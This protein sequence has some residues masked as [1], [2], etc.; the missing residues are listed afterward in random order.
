MAK[1]FISYS[2]KDI[3][4]AKQL[5]GE[6]Q[7]SD[8]DYW[9]DWDGIPPTV[10]WW[11]EIEKGI[12][13]ADIFLF[14]ISPDSSKSEV[15]L[16]EIN[17]AVKNGKRLIPLVAREIS[18]DEAP[19]HLNH[20]NWIFFR[21]TDDFDAALEKLLT[22]I[23]TDYEWAAAHRRLQ[24]KALEWKRNNKEKSFLL[25]GKDL[26]DAELDLATNSSKDPHPT[27]LQREYIFTSRK[28]AD[29]QRR[30]TTGISSAGIIAL[31]ILAAFG[32][33][34]A[35]QA[36]N[37]A[38]TAQANLVIAQTA[39]VD[40]QNKQVL[41]DNNA[42]TAVANEQEA[43]RQ[44][45]I[46]RAG[47]LAAQSESLISKDFRS[48]LLLGIE[49]FQLLDNLQTRG[50]LLD[51]TNSNPA[52]LQYLA[53]HT[54]MVMSVA[55]SPDGKTLASSSNDNTIIL[56]DV[57]SRAPLGQPLTGHSQ[58]VSSVAFSPDGR[59]LASGSWD[60]TIIL[61]DIST[62]KPIGQPLTEHTDRVT[63]VA[64]SP[65][66]RT[67][68]SGSKDNTII[69]WDVAT[70]KPISRPLP[71]NVDNGDLTFSSDGRYFASA[72]GCGKSNST[73]QCIQGG[74][75]LWDVATRT[76]TGLPFTGH[77][78]R[79]ESVAFSPDSRILASGS[80]DNTIILWDVAT[81]K[82]I[83][84]PLIGHANWVRSVAFS[85]DSKILASGD[86]DATIFIWDVSTGRPISQPLIGHTS[87][88]SSLAFSPDG[89]TLASGSWDF[90]IS[91]WGVPTLLISSTAAP[92][93]PAGQPFARHTDRVN[94]VAF[95]P[96]GKI[97]ASGSNDTSV[98]LW[99][100]ATGNS[101]DQPLIGLTSPLDQPY[102]VRSV[103]FSPDGKILASGGYPD[104]I[105]WDI[106]THKL[107]GQLLTEHT[108]WVESVAFSPDGKILASGSD[109]GNIILTDVSTGE[110]V[111]QPLI[112]HTDWVMSVAFSP[113]GNTLASGS[114]DGSVILWEISS[115]KP[116]D[117]S[118]TW[119]P[120]KINSVAFSPDGKTLASAYNDNTIILW[121]V[122]SGDPI[123]QPLIGHTHEV[124]SIAFSPDGKNLISG[125]W[126]STVILWDLATH[127]P[128]GQPLVGHTN[129]VW[130]V[131]FSP[132]GKTIA[133]SS[134]DNTIILWDVDPA[135][136]I[137][138]SCQ[139]AG[140]NFTR[141]EWEKFGFTEPYRKTCEQWPLESET[142]TPSASSAP[143][144]FLPKRQR[145]QSESTIFPLNTIL[146]QN[147][148]SNGAGLLDTYQSEY[149]S[150][151]A[152][153][154]VYSLGNSEYN[155]YP[156]E[157]PVQA[158][159]RIIT[160]Q[161]KQVAGPSN[162][163]TGFG[164]VCR[165]SPV[166]VTGYLLAISGDGY[167]TIQKLNATDIIKLI[168]WKSFAVIAQGNTPNIITA[169]CIGNKLTLIVNNDVVLE[170][171]DDE[172]TCNG[173]C[174][175]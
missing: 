126:D 110:P 108:N 53:N 92:L 142:A 55:F 146:Y 148:F 143:H 144:R 18:G 171:S 147:D 1:V 87:A 58:A 156:T 112:G 166:D 118:P 15:C 38:A 19:P 125:S 132:N 16:R 49:S 170:T 37:N 69:L 160:I 138:K 119:R 21:S 94:S 62:G 41:A 127:K 25:R 46:S 68:A 131:A 103:A 109:D 155:W 73:G 14:L 9:I 66:G 117:Q 83:G 150:V 74:I 42:A 86:E 98:I 75:I 93:A 163:N 26:Q 162:N 175:S 139:R 174:I 137:A 140:R 105:L 88:I 100:V 57:A 128:I 45:K 61:W 164:V 78:G 10:D 27:D 13:E 167:A 129:W 39:Q 165:Y 77:A 151:G 97:L 79:V 5:T 72:A 30:I 153:N 67:L 17:H 172:F 141:A 91:L 173:C 22:G 106:A 24:V 34:Q 54:S 168:D 99:D 90:T 152:S 3:E 50:T 169:S 122:S 130:S 145:H 23:H 89:M 120:F 7:K 114:H 64:F 56:W 104:I 31:A 52:L 134:W 28:A 35:V 76:P 115:G 158:S 154:G 123:G 40:A 159:D 135:S 12:E 81:R 4:F 111:G 102:W 71:G 82:P 65:D 36:T 51:I 80:N 116:L 11:K 32:F 101:I 107:I 70:R 44:A 33:Y 84:Q 60:N 133:S 95:S 2:R 113:D 85:P 8:L 43:N 149:F 157:I 29:R 161:A 63:S 124:N 96:D 121:D 136:S 59:T 6:L 48:S 20:L 47:E